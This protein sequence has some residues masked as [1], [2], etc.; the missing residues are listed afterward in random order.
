MPKIEVGGIAIN[1]RQWGRGDPLVLIHGLGMSSDLWWHQV[2]PFSDQYHVVAI[3]L[4]GFGR[5]DRPRGPNLYSVD[6]FTADIA[7]VIRCL[8]LAPVHVLGTSMGGYCA[9]ALGLSAPELCRSLSLCHTGCRSS[10]ADDVLAARTT[11]L[12]SQSMDE[13]ATLV[14]AQALAQPADPIVTEWLQERVASNDQEIYAQVL[15][16]GLRSFDAANEITS[17]RLPTLAL[18]GQHD[19]IIEPKRGRELAE[20]IPDSTLVEIAGVGHLSYI[21]KPDAFNRSILEFLAQH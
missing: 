2:R 3:D 17:I 12:K 20:R 18:I 4:R 21:E 15:T 1:V 5:S 9:I 19:R 6:N 14:A 10:I 7:S 11:A 16:E 8:D 13:Y